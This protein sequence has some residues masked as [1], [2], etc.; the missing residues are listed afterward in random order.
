M[1]TSKGVWNGFIHHA[2]AYQAEQRQ[3][4]PGSQ[5]ARWRTRCAALGQCPHTLA[6][7][8]HCSR[9]NSANGPPTHDRSCKSAADGAGKGCRT[10]RGA[11]STDPLLHCFFCCCCYHD[12]RLHRMARACVV[13]NKIAAQ[14]SSEG[15]RCSIAAKH[16]AAPRCK[17][18]ISDSHS[19]EEERGA[20]ALR[21]ACAKEATH[22]RPSVQARSVERRESSDFGSGENVVDETATDLMPGQATHLY[23]SS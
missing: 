3:E 14:R 7:G 6:S 4:Q 19:V 12:R 11:L 17:P 20:L 8:S 22:T 18:G 15:S 21:S 23:L 10:T 9:P 16:S 5:K 1:R 2:L 13:L